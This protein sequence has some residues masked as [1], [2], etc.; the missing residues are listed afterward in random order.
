MNPYELHELALKVGS[1]IALDAALTQAKQKIGE[2][3]KVLCDWKNDLFLLAFISEYKIELESKEINVQADEQLLKILSSDTMKAVFFERMR[4]VFLSKSRVIS[5]IAIGFI[6]AKV[7]AE[8][9]DPS[10]EEEHLFEALESLS[11][12]DLRAFQTE[13][14][15]SMEKIKPADEKRGYPR[16]ISDGILIY[17]V[18]EEFDS[19]WRR[20]KTI[21]TGVINLETF[22][23]SWARKLQSCGFI[24][25]ETQL[26]KF[27]YQADSERHVDEDG[28]VERHIT[29]VVILNEASHLYALERC[30][31]VVPAL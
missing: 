18:D 15:S 28:S 1:K 13:Y 14:K 26:Q 21:N 2:M 3:M 25:T 6:S 16:K 29:T 22:Y 4:N 24:Q 23:G 20:D 8:E 11:D 17:E 9:R 27:D 10:A 12:E 7:F 31:P 19:G 30:P 5:P